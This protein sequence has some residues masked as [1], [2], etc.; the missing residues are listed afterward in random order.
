M[1]LADLTA[2]WLEEHVAQL[3]APERYLDSVEQ[4]ESFWAGLRAQRLLPEPFTVS[5]VSNGLVDQFIAWR[6]AQGVSPPTISRDLAALRGPI[7]WGL[8]AEIG[9]L[10]S[11]LR[12]KDV[13]GRKKP[14]DLEWSPEQI[15][16]L[17]DAARASAERQHV[18]I[19][20]MIMLSTHARSEATL[21]LEAETQIKRGLIHFLRPDEDQTRKRRTIVPI[22]PTLAPWLEGITGKVVRYRVAR[23]E[24]AQAAGKTAFFEKPT[25][26][27]GNAFAGVLRAAHELRPDL[28]FAAQARDAAG[29]LI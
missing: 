25:A 2:A 15:A 22:C 10:T 1:L 18:H 20:A 14:K 26:D 3:D 6:V 23:S 7:N 27:I 8:K 12:V 24:K 28:G 17:L 21:E 11:A 29:E 9:R 5:K 19:F 4:L 16:V 13:K